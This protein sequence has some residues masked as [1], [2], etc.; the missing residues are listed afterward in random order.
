MAGEHLAGGGDVHEA[1]APAAHAGFR[2]LRVVVGHDH[3]D[4]EDAFQP[5]ALALDELDRLIAVIARDQGGAIEIGPA[6][7]LHVRDL[8]TLRP[9]LDGEID[10]RPTLSSSGGGS[11]R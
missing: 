10:I 11:A 9:E 6:V 1:L 2:A 5:L 8:E 3:V 7:I 4:G